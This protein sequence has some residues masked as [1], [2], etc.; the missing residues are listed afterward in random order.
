MPILAR[1]SV[2]AAAMRRAAAAERARARERSDGG[3]RALA[4]E[5]RQ[6]RGR[7]PAG[8]RRG[9]RHYFCRCAS[10]WRTRQH[11][12]A[13]A[14]CGEIAAD[15]ALTRRVPQA[16]VVP[17][18]DAGRDAGQVRR[19]APR[20]LVRRAG[21]RDVRARGPDA[22]LED[23]RLHHRDAQ[24]RLAPGP[25]AEWP[26]LRSM[27]SRGRRP[28]RRCQHQP[29]RS[30]RPGQRHGRLLR[31]RGAQGVR[32][33]RQRA[34]ALRVP[35]HGRGRLRPWQ[36]RVPFAARTRLRRI[37]AA[38]RPQTQRFRGDEARRRRGRRRG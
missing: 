3:A 19:L 32:H 2:R 26:R 17:D 12:R 1:A 14:R 25:R 16:R 33:R 36:R 29:K 30:S 5:P 38:P 10:R 6:N 13:R 22:G 18:D 34:G 20:A 11:H 23:V 37:A 27:P 4:N 8:G 21:R 7:T 9:R 24:A 35:R 31:V 15:R 28:V